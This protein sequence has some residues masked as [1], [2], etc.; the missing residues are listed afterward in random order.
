M[1]ESNTS[2]WQKHNPWI[3]RQAS[4]ADPDRE[5]LDLPTRECSYQPLNVWRHPWKNY[6]QS[7][8]EYHATQYEWR[9]EGELLPETSEYHRKRQVDYIVQ[10][11]IDVVAASNA[12]IARAGSL[13]RSLFQYQEH[14]FRKMA[15]RHQYVLEQAKWIPSVSEAMAEV[16]RAGAT[17]SYSRPPPSSPR[18]RGAPYRSKDTE[19]IM[20]K[21]RPDVQKGRMF[22]FGATAIG[23]GQAE[24]EATHSTLVLKRNSDRSWIAEKSSISDL[25]RVNLYFD[26]KDNSPVEI[27]PHSGNSTKSSVFTAEISAIADSVDENRYQV[28]TRTDSHPPQ[29]MQDNGDRMSWGNPW[30]D[31]GRRLFLRGATF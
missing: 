12:L 3:H 11:V 25:R 5:S 26:E 6:N 28:G 29:A 2:W 27:P 20:R 8:G 18:R 30:V 1:Q 21:L 24:I 13:S 17:A 14:E 9:L 19:E 10:N 7:R 4:P 31:G 15:E 23:G 22:L 16:L